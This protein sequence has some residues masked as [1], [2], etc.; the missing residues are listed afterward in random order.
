MKTDAAPFDSAPGVG[1]DGD[2]A[3]SGHRAAARPCR[4]L[5]RSLLVVDPAQNNAFRA[6][7]SR[8][9]SRARPCRRIGRP[10]RDQRPLDRCAPDDHRQTLWRCRRNAAECG[11][12]RRRDPRSRASAS[13]SRG[14][15][16]WTKAGRAGCSSSTA[17]RSSLIHPEDFKTPL[18]DQID[19]LI[20]AR[21]CAVPV[22][23]AA[24]G[25]TRRR[26]GAR[27]GPSY[28]YQLTADDLQRLRAVR[29]RRRHRRLP[30]QRQHLS[31]SSSSSCRSSNVVAGLRPEEFFLRGSIVESRP[32]IRRIR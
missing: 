4:R 27:C 22:A 10:I 14:P 21:R 26:G 32:P 11:Y 7:Q 29:P 17:S 5:R 23:G 8:V 19:V 9:G 25:G 15:A 28:A 31:R 16:A 1:F 12:R 2:P 13:I 3:A 18:G 6:H 20:I 24:A 30:E